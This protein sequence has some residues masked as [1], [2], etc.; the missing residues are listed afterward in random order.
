MRPAYVEA[1][2]RVIKPDEITST[3]AGVVAVPGSWTTRKLAS[4]NFLIVFGWQNVILETGI[5]IF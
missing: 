4:D 1:A 5:D 3:L 2:G